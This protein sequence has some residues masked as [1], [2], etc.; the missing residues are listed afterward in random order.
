MS[1]DDHSA[2]ARYLDPAGRVVIYPSK[3][4]RKR[5]VL[6][7]LASKLEQEREYSEREIND[8]LDRYHTFGDWAL[9]RRDLYEAGFVERTPDGAKYWLS[10]RTG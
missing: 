9:L 2:I 7:Y 4:S 1:D 6:A 10:R 3:A 8:L 5:Q